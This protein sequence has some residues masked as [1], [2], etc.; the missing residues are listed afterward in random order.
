MTKV[1]DLAHDTG[2][3][4]YNL[5][6]IYQEMSFVQKQAYEAAGILENILNEEEVNSEVHAKLQEVWDLLT[7]ASD[8]LL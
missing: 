1:R 5:I 3:D 2:E 8:A 6:E 4:F 7:K